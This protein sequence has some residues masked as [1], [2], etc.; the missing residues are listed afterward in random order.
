MKSTRGRGGIVS[1]V[2]YE[3]ITAVDVQTALDVSLNY[4][5]YVPPTNASA[6]PVFQT[7]SEFNNI[8][9][10]LQLTGH[11]R[12]PWQGSR[13]C[14]TCRDS[15]RRTALPVSPSGNDFTGII[16]QRGDG[17][18]PTETHGGSSFAEVSAFMK[19]QLMKEHAT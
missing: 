9:R 19:D 10:W 16:A 8:P 7:T 11:R 1:D 2:L 12:R 13:M 17:S 5:G 6:T 15:P 3:D 4:N 14:G 18:R